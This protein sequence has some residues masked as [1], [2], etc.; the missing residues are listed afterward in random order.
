MAG[1]YLT[2]WQ[3]IQSK[4]DQA[5]KDGIF[6]KS[7]KPNNPAPTKIADY[8]NE[9]FNPADYG[10]S[11]EMV[12]L[13]SNSEKMSDQDYWAAVAQIARVDAVNPQAPSRSE[14]QPARRTTPGPF[15]EAPEGILQEA[16]S[17]D[18]PNPVN[19]SAKGQDN[20]LVPTQGWAG[21]DVLAKLEKMKLELHELGDKL[22]GSG[23][24]WNE[25]PKVST[26]KP[27]QDVMKKIH[28]LWKQIDELS[29]SLAPGTVQKDSLS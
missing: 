13:A 3:D 4:W 24:D 8:I 21:G 15:G 11:P 17:I 20:A 14:E 18:T 26:D 7:K 12:A 25:K 16:G 22:A 23:A 5:Q 27:G 19:A 1:D 6:A 9:D 10:M 29:S 2:N 28:S